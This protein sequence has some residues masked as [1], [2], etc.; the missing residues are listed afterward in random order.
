MKTIVAFLSFVFAW[1]SASASPLADRVRSTDAVTVVSL[2][3]VVATVHTNASGVRITAFAAD[4]T[5][6]R[7]LKGT[8]PDKIHLKGETESSFFSQGVSLGTTR[9]LV[10]L[11]R[12]GDSYTPSGSEAIAP[13]WGSGVPRESRVVW[14]NCTTLEEAET[15]I[16]KAMKE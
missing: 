8:L 11:K 6:E 7:T 12:S 16:K 3:N 1:S 5:V 10:F 2:S 9:F 4:A 14:P 13:I 15:A